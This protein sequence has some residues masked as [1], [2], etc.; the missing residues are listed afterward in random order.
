MNT[1]RPHHSAHLSYSRTR[2]LTPVVSALVATIAPIASAEFTYFLEDFN[3]WSASAETHATCSFAEFP[4]NTFITNQYES[5]GVLF[6]GFTGN[7]V[8]VG[9]SGFP[10]DGHGID[11]NQG[12]ELT[13][14]KPTFAIGAHGPGTWSYLLY[15]GDTLLY[16]SMS[17]PS[18]FGSFAGVVSTVPF[19]RVQLLG[20]PKPG[21]LLT[22]VYVDNIYFSSIPAPAVLW[23]AGVAGL[24]SRGR[25]RES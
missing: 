11:G 19:D 5:L 6:T 21:G 15:Q 13:F 20:F 14:D 2:I 25:R 12:I 1:T 9:W 18:I 24:R 3:G 10:L 7:V 16:T 23:V 8:N 22:D 17:G 4:Q